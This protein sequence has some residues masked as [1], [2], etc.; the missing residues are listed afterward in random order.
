MGNNRFGSDTMLRYVV[1]VP[2]PGACTFG[3]FNRGGALMGGR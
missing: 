3:M 2:L 1:T